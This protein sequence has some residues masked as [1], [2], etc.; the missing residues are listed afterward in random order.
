MSD[1]AVYFECT[2]HE[3]VYAPGRCD[4][5]LESFT[6]GLQVAGV[7]VQYVSVLRLNVDVFEEVIPHVG[8]IAFRVIPGQTCRGMSLCFVRFITES[9]D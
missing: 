7:P 1:K 3:E 9:H 5:L 2:S 4:L 8:V 6:L